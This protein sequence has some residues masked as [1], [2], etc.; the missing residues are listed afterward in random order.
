MSGTATLNNIR[1]AFVLYPSRLQIEDSLYSFMLDKLKSQKSQYDYS[2]FDQKLPNKII[3]DFCAKQSLDC[4]DL[5]DDMKTQ[6]LQDLKPQYVERELNWNFWGN[7]LAAT[8]EA[9][10]VAELLKKQ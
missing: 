1:I 4:I 5:T 9:K 6:Y 2:Q 3:K 8:L 10:A 7:Q